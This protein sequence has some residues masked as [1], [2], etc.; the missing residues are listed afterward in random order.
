MRMKPYVR[1]LKLQGVIYGLISSLPTYIKVNILLLDLMKVKVFNNNNTILVFIML[2]L[3]DMSRNHF[4]QFGKGEGEK[5]YCVPAKW[6]GNGITQ[7]AFPQYET[8]KRKPKFNSCC[9]GGKR[10]IANTI[11]KIWDNNRNT[12]TPDVVRGPDNF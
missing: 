8:A 2:E 6:D 12:N 7:P 11:L 3:Q 9:L 10:R 4:L 1:V 5:W